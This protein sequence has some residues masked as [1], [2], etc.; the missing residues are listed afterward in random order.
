[1]GVLI[2]FGLILHQVYFP[3]NAQKTHVERAQAL[4]N[5]LRCP[6]CDIQNLKDSNVPLAKS[7]R[8]YVLD[9]LEAGESEEQIIDFLTDR[10]GKA[11]FLEAQGSQWVVALWSF[12]FILFLALLVW[13]KRLRKRL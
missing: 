1:M 4:L 5:K 2:M 11:I 7:I 13:Y 12:P 8:L 3:A 9:S 6:T 10:Y